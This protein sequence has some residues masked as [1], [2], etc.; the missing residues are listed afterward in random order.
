[1]HCG[2]D[3]RA[4]TPNALLPHSREP[5][6]N[7]VVLSSLAANATEVVD[8]PTQLICISDIYLFMP[9][10]KYKRHSRAIH[11]EPGSPESDTQPSHHDRAFPCCFQ[12]SQ[13]QT[14]FNDSSQP[15]HSCMSCLLSAN[16]CWF[17]PDLNNGLWCFGFNVWAQ[18]GSPTSSSSHND[19]SRSW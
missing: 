12:L 11:S 19:C 2:A 13:E 8:R 10:D 7:F 1:M 18:C 17:A 15:D 5:H 6:C 4:D 14:P 16:L 3:T 9:T